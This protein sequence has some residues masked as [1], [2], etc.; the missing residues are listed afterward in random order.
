[1]YGY[2]GWA[3]AEYNEIET[4]YSA[5][6]VYTG[7]IPNRDSDVIGF[8]G[9]H[10]SLSGPVQALDHRYGES[11]LELFYK[12]QITDFLSFKPDAQYIFSP[13][14]DGRDAFVVGFRLELAF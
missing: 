2:F 3:P 4:S 7:L 6:F 9:S 11:A 14:G 12:A 10:A 13:G 1:M 5:G 8:G